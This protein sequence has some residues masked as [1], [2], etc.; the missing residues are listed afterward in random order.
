[1]LKLS[2][3][4]WKEFNLT[5]MFDISQGRKW[6]TKT[7]IENNPGSIP[8]VSCAGTN[9]GIMGFINPDG[10]SKC[11]VI[12]NKLTIAVSG[13]AGATFYQGIKTAVNS[14]VLILSGKGFTQKRVYLFLCAIVGEA[15]SKFCYG[16]KASQD[17][18]SR[19]TLSIPVTSN[20]QPDYDFM[21]QYIRERENQ[22]ITGLQCMLNQMM[23]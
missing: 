6:I 19:L 5:D 20:G 10:I 3:R 23:R 21:E 7:E 17:R 4:E 18:V 14:G 9:N 2:D 12:E 13:S 15:C 22:I 16:I 1:M 11:T 8:L